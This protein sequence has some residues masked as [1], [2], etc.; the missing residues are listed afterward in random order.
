[1]NN[2]FQK[3][4]INKLLELLW[5]GAGS[6]FPARPGVGRRPG[7]LLLVRSNKREGKILKTRH[8]E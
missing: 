1:M 6:V 8:K 5:H 3:I 7:S 4:V 2:K